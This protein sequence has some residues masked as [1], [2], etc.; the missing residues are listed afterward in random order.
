VAA[1][2]APTQ[3]PPVP[4]NSDPNFA[5]WINPSAWEVAFLIGINAPITKP[6]VAILN[7]WA[8]AEG[9]IGSSNNPLAS[10]GLNPGATRCISQC[11][12]SSP[13]MAYATLA[14]GVAANVAFLKN[15]HYSGIIQ[16]FQA[17]NYQYYAN[18]TSKEAIQ[19]AAGQISAVW[20]QINIS[21]WCRGCQGGQYPNVLYEL[22]QQAQSNPV[23]ANP[24]GGPSVGTL[25]AG[26]PAL[27][28]T[29]AKAVAAAVP[30]PLSWTD[31]LAK[32][33]GDITAASFWE[34]VGLF[35]L[36]AALTV[37]GAVIF[38]TSTG[39]SGTGGGTRVVPV[40]V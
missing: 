33:F 11:G 36:G 8:Q 17:D 1:T 37:G 6:N 29:D 28:G 25:L 2:V 40:P 19:S 31:A 3:A 38:M 27:A 30:N 24:A 10:S 4:A 12:S 15:N 34:R 21:G 18:P 39:S 9:V 14:Q 22:M 26:A 20:T 5:S 35:A 7:A 16:A 32:F 23:W 13:V